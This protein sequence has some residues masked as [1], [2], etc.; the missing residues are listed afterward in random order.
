[1]GG[2]RSTSCSSFFFPSTP[3]PPKKRLSPSESRGGT[4]LTLS[5]Q[6]KVLIC[7][8]NHTAQEASQA[9]EEGEFSLQLE[10]T[11]EDPPLGLRPTES[12][13]RS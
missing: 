5:W 10:L 11:F 4:S 2:S 6:S 12:G 13:R 1:M 8:Q 3:T 9:E 7:D